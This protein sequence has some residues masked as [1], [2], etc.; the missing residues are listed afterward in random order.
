M[1]FFN[2]L[3]FLF[4][5]KK[6]N[7]ISKTHTLRIKLYIRL[8]DRAVQ[9][10]ARLE[11]ALHRR[12]ARHRRHDLVPAVVAQHPEHLEMLP[13]RPRLLEDLAPAADDDC[14]GG[15]DERRL[16]AVGVVDLAPVHVQGLFGGRLERVLE[17]RDGG[18]G[19]VFGES[20]RDDVD[21]GEAYL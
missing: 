13:L 6:P 17:R 16:A 19:Q 10:V 1:N 12:D 7:T 2:Y 3:Y 21:L 8:L 14:V 15:D 18:L 11:R 9:L 4:K 20:R 5:K